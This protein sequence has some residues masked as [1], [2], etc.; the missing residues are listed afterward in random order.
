MCRWNT[1]EE[2]L[3]KNDTTSPTVATKIVFITLTIDAS[4]GLKVVAM[5]VPSAFLYTLMEHKYPKVHIKFQG[6]IVDLMVKVDTNLYR[7][8]VSTDSKGHMILY[9]EM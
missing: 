7:K 3:K 4:E 9:V 1:T 2:H 6:K 8:T 5:V